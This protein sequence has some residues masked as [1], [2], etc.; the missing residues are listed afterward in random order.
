LGD[1][2][3]AA[4]GFSC[5]SWAPLRLRETKFSLDLSA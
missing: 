4:S 1:V 3:A 2:A 5:V